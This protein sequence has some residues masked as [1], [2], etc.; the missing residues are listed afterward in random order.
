MKI[1]TQLII[2]KFLQH[3]MKML[4]S[5]EAKSR[6]NTWQGYFT[7]EE[8]AS[9]LKL[10]FGNGITEKYNLKNATQA[11]MLTL[12]EDE[13]Y[14]V[15]YI[16]R[17]WESTFHS[18]LTLPID[19]EAIDAVLDQIGFGVHYLR[20]KPSKDFDEYDISNLKSIYRKTGLLIRVY[21]IYDASIKE[22]EIDSVTTAPKV[23]YDTEGEAED[24]IV[25]LE[26][27]NGI[28]HGELTIH[29][30]ELFNKPF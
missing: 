27:E 24:E 12:I 16:L 3:Y 10:R 23:F 11:E 18:S 6:L 9:I 7:S 1:R 25:R 4:E 8:L 15:Q 30:K 28:D 22:E 21:G 20:Y 5:K 17:N 14:L 13:I 26:S 29:S 19:K 2:R